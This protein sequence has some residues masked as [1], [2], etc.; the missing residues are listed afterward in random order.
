MNKCTYCKRKI[1]SELLSPM[2]MGS[3]YTGNICG[4]CALELSNAELGIKR[5]EFQGE[6]AEWNRVEAINHYKKTKQKYDYKN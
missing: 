3:G 5:T 2:F 4:V 6:T 1:P